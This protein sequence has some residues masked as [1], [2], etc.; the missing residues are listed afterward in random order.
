MDPAGD[1]MQNYRIDRVAYNL[2]A[3]DKA[4]ELIEGKSENL[5]DE[6]SKRFR[7]TCTKHYWKRTIK[8]V[9]PITSWLPNYEIKKDL[10]A[11]FIVGI[12]V[13]IFQV[14]QSMGYCLIA[15][16]PPVHGLYTAFFPALVYSFLGTS[17]HSAVGAFAIVSGVMTG[18]VVTQVMEENGVSL[19]EIEESLET[20]IPFSTTATSTLSDVD[21]SGISVERTQMISGIQPIEV[22][23]AL[24]MWMGIYMIAFGVIRLGFIS[25]YLSEQLISGF[26]TAASLYVFTSQLRY[27]FGVHLPYN[28]GFFAIIQSYIDL[29]QH[30]KEINFATTLISIICCA[31]LL[32]FKIYVNEKMRKAGINIPFPIELAVVIGGTLVSA[33]MDLNNSYNVQIVGEIKKGLPSPVTPR[34]EVLMTT[35]SRSIPL[36][37]V[38]YTI[39]L[40]VGKLYGAKHGYDVSANQELVALGTT[41][42]VS[43]CFGCLPS[44]ASLPRSAVQEQA[45]GRTQLA[46]LVNCGMMLIVL[47][48]IGPLLEKLPNVCK[49]HFFSCNLTKSVVCSCFRNCSGFEEFTRTGERIQPLQKSIDVRCGNFYLKNEL[50]NDNYFYNAKAIWMIS[51]LGVIILDV[52]YGLYCGVIFSLLVLIYKSSRP[53]AYLLGS[54]NNSDVYVPIKKYVSAKEIAGIKIYQ[55]CGP[56]HFAN[57]EYFKSHLFKKTEFTKKFVRKFLSKNRTSVIGKDGNSVEENEAR[58]KYI[59]YDNPIF[60]IENIYEK[61]SSSLN[62]YS[63]GYKYLIIDCSMISY[64][65]A[66]GIRMLRKIIQEYEKREISV[67]LTC[68]ISHVIRILERDRFFVEF[69]KD[70]VYISIHDAVLHIKSE[71]RHRIGNETEKKVEISR[72]NSLSPTDGRLTSRRNN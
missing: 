72:G 51:F 12:T 18:N 32:F 36:A 49:L 59:C 7:I 10:L 61:R 63:N 42:I 46:S 60:N 29:V 26:A 54:V 40:T 34:A 23:N 48:F 47:Y 55:F 20:N 19:R 27:L 67:Y 31:I 71:S 50:I 39:T 24:S 6:V 44:A 3:F 13:A 45:G 65:D 58:T 70:R 43:S 16:V 37:I 21:I 9:L 11:D 68:C 62:V 1:D 69:S 64:C 8:K 52:D 2:P 14:P 28:S 5:C 41:N 4:F 17:R 33:L 53:K 57:V 35:W 66:A 22:A 30:Y 56:L 38:G 15:H 25:I